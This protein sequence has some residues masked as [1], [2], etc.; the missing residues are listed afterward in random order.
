MI[1][2]F[3]VCVFLLS[4]EFHYNTIR[5]ICHAAISN[6]SLIRF[7]VLAYRSLHPFGSYIRSRNVTCNTCS[8]TGNSV[9]EALIYS[10]IK[11]AYVH[12]SFIF[13]TDVF[14]I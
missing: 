3:I 13:N 7:S 2:L 11:L 14:E 9:R 1:A 10:K 4:S 5:S 12:M 8:I 6:S